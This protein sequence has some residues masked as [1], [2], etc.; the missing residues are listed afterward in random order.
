MML[1]AVMAMSFNTVLHAQQTQTPP[2]VVTVNGVAQELKLVAIGLNSTSQRDALGYNRPRAWVTYDVDGKQETL[3]IHPSTCRILFGNA[4]DGVR[5]L[6]FFDVQTVAGNQ[7]RLSGLAEKQ[8]VR[9]Y[10]TQGHLHATLQAANG[11][12]SVNMSSLPRGLYL[13]K[14]GQ[15]VF[16]FTNR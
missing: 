10:D 7:L 6:R 15:Q 16:K 12:A 4:I 14:A 1:T 3:Y 9:V 5:G 11:S 8:T 2:A 13:I